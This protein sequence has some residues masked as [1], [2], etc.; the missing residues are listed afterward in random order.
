MHSGVEPVQVV[1]GTEVDL[2]AGGMGV[3]MKG[4]DGAGAQEA[5]AHL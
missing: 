3:G 4:R 5:P 1:D 2:R